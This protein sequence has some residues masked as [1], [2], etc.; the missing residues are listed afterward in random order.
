VSFE[1]REP[2]DPD[3][4][5][6]PTESDVD[7]AFAQIIAGWEVGSRP[8]WPQ[9]SASDDGGQQPGVTGP[10]GPGGAGATAGDP[11][12]GSGFG[13]AGPRR[14]RGFDPGGLE[15]DSEP[16]EEI[17]AAADFAGLLEPVDDEDDHFIPPEPPPLPRPQPATVGAVLLFALGIVLLTV[18][19]LIGLSDQYGLPLGLLSITGAIVWLVARLRQ[20]P[21]T[22]SGWDDGAQ[23]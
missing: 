13:P 2:D 16:T 14:D 6:E 7:A 5:R 19:E 18:P 20:G 3:P 1:R 9:G 12:L 22:D 11:G 10:G 17:P 4:A 15:A 23:L 8:Q 21:P